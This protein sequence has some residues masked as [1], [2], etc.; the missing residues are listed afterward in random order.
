LA[1]LD[2][3]TQK[4]ISLL[5]LFGSIMQQEGDTNAAY[6]EAKAVLVQLEED[7]FFVPSASTPSTQA[8]SSSPSSTG[9]ERKPFT[10][11]IKNPGAPASDKQKGLINR[12]TDG[13]APD[14]TG[15]TMQQA[16]D[17]ID[18]LNR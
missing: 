10:G 12:L 13:N 3:T 4:R 9:G 2:T 6:A 1:Q 11:S 15:Y 14:L 8:A 17:L 5:S 18:E 7:N 16:S